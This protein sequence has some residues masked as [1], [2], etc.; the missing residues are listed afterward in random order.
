MIPHPG[1]PRLHAI[2]CEAFYNSCIPMLRLLT[3]YC[4][5][6][7]IIPKLQKLSELLISELQDLLTQIRDLKCLQRMPMEQYHFSNTYHRSEFS[8][9][10]ENKYHCPDFHQPWAGM[11][12]KTHHWENKS[13]FAVFNGVLF[14]RGAPAVYLFSL[15][16]LFCFFSSVLLL[17]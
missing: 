7:I 14:S 9:H 5:H 1:V 6:K 4:S 2:Y 10:N 3:D 8:F 11:W 12:T 13:G 17:G 15:S 16:E